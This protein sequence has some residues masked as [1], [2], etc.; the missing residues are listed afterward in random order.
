MSGSKLPLV[1][2]L[3]GGGLSVQFDEHCR[4]IWRKI[5]D[6]HVIAVDAPHGEG[7]IV[8]EVLGPSEIKPLQRH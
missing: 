5:G 2:E 1:V 8:S 6:R 7:F 3:E 4:V